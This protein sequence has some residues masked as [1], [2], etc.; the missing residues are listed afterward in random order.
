MAIRIAE[1][2]GF[3]FGVSRAVKGA[4][5]C[6]EL[7]GEFVTLGELIHNPFTVAKLTKLGI[8]CI[9]FI[10]EV[11]ENETVIIR[12][13]GVPKAVYEQLIDKKIEYKDFT[14]PYV[15]KIHNIVE[16]ADNDSE[17][18][19][20]FGHNQH[21][22]VVG[23]KGYTR[24]CEVFSN[25]E[26]FRKF[27]E[28]CKKM[29]YKN[30]IVVAQTTFDVKKWGEIMNFLKKDYTN[31]KIFDTICKATD[32]RQAE[33]STM[34]RNNDA[35]FVI[36]GRGSSNTNR[37]FEVC[38]ENCANSFFVENENEVLRSQVDGHEDIAIFAGASTPS[39]Q[40]EA[41]ARQIAMLQNTTHK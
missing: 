13:H 26:E 10:D 24:D 37:L 5:E 41:V 14:C 38:R 25:I 40:I 4:Y 6:A 30:G 18:V 12:S 19:I 35:C 34:S 32:I 31:L 17:F 15:K 9:N 36:G 23:I 21:P 22:E 28:N 11:R 29:P 7:E 33:A 39:E 20:I 27:A 2:A 16:R 3:C 8:R 1:H